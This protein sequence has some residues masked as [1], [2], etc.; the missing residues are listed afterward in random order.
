M[1]QFLYLHFLEGRSELKLINYLENKI[2]INQNI[3]NDLKAS[4]NKG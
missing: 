3:L 1:M 4:L 2:D